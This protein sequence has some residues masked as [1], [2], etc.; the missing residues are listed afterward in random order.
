[1]WLDSSGPGT[2]C[3]DSR[4]PEGTLG[5]ASIQ[6]TKGDPQGQYEGVGP[7]VYGKT[8]TECVSLCQI[9]YSIHIEY[10]ATLG[11]SFMDKPTGL[12]REQLADW[13]RTLPFRPYHQTLF[14]FR[15]TI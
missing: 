6:N 14:H 13:I 8:E 1:M 3:L 2:A 12:M 5:G 7:V 4:V 10:K 9:M 15:T 11:I